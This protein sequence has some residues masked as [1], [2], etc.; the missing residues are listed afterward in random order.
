MMMAL[1]K[2]STCLAPL[3]PL[4]DL[5]ERLMLGFSC[6]GY[7]STYTLSPNV[8]P[9]HRPYSEWL[10]VSPQHQP[11]SHESQHMC[12]FRKRLGLSVTNTSARTAMAARSHTIVRR[13]HC[14]D[15]SF[16]ESSRWQ[17]SV[18]LINWEKTVVSTLESL[19]ET[20]LP[21]SGM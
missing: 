13:S 12:F 2:S 19:I 3:E 14:S 5:D 8:T 9:G 7:K 16:S 1:L 6:I 10:L 17:E 4:S 18:G 20:S 21:L 11:K 15:G